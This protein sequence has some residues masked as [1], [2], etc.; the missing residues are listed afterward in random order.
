MTPTQPE[1]EDLF[2]AILRRF[3]VV[4]L[5][6]YDAHA[7]LLATS[8]KRELVSR[9]VERVPQDDALEASSL[10]VPVRGLIDTAA[11]DDVGTTLLVQGLLLEHLGQAIYASV[12]DNRHVST[13]SRTLAA[14]AV[15]ASTTVTTQVPD[16]IRDSIGEGEALFARFAEATSDVLAGLDALGEGVDE[17]FGTPFALQFRDIVGEFVASVI[18]VCT[19]LGMNRRKVVSHLAGAFMG[20]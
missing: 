13:E 18:P 14:S 2:W 6:Q 3:E 8:A 20:F 10:G 4:A 17:T 7:A 12:T 11:N 9:L 16:R 15:A 1:L 5:R 19:G